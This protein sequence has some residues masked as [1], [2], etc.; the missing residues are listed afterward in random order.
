MNKYKQTFI[1][2]VKT[3]VIKNNP[4][5]VKEYYAAN[6]QGKSVVNKHLG[7]RI[8]FTSWGKGKLSLGS[9]HTKKVAV[10]QCL[11]KLLEVAEFNNF[12][13][14][15]EKDSMAVLGY[16]NFKAKVKIDGKTENVRIAVII[17]TDGKIYYSHE[18]NKKIEP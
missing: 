17:K 18:I 12:G 15:K 4:I 11:S 7:F 16:L 6:L 9:V 14:R 13:N 2:C 3:G 1:P 5:A 10:L 8:Y